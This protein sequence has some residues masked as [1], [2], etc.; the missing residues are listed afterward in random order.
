MNNR[1]LLTHLLTVFYCCCLTT[2]CAQTPQIPAP[3][4]DPLPPRT[5]FE[6]LTAE[7]N[8]RI[9]LALNM[10]ALLT[11]KKSRDYLIGSLQDANGKKYDVEVRASGKFRRMKAVNPPLKIK[12]K[13][14]ILAKEGLDSL[15]KLKI[16]MPWF[17]TPAGEDYL[18]REY[19]AYKIFE[20]ISPKYVRAR[21]IQLSLQNT[22][23]AT[24]NMPALLVEDED[25]TATRLGG[26]L[27]T[28]YGIPMD[29]LESEQTALT[30]LYQYFIGNTDWDF[31]ML[32]NVRIVETPDGQIWPLP[33]D[34][35]F[36]GFVNAP[37]ATPA[38]DAGIRHVRERSF[39]DEGLK[40]N[41]VEAAVKLLKSR[42]ETFYAVCASKYA[43]TQSQEHMAAYL[44][45]YFEKM[46][47][48]RI[49]PRIMQTDD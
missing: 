48:K 15:N 28:R 24:K 34:F 3:S 49:P 11:Q 7:E 26:K 13:K 45:L 14:K 46:G 19:L 29:S 18:V 20:E 23:G 39:K 43:N 40:K 36:C 47:N 25:E 16:V 38:S 4:K 21:L 22:K 37:Y 41:A 8:P 2:A 12:F 1:M 31:N 10:S 44:Q 6:R 17:D 9:T 32:R 30:A 35:D 33:Y 42:K 5:I 27:V